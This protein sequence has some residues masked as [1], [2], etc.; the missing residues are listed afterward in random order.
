[1]PLIKNYCLLFC[2]AALLASLWPVVAQARPVAASLPGLHVVGSQIRDAQNHPIILKG[3]ARPGL[4]YLCHGEGPYDLAS[5]QAMQS[6]G[7]NAVNLPLS[8]SFWLNTDGACPD[9]RQTVAATIQHAETAGLYVVINLHSAQP[10]QSE[11]PAG[12]AVTFW[13][14]F[15]GAYGADHD[16]LIE[17]FNEPHNVSWQVWHDGGT[18]QNAN[19]SYQAV[20]MQQL[21]TLANTLAP[22][23]LVIVSGLNYGYDL[24]GLAQGYAIQS[25]NLIYSVHL[26]DYPEKQPADWPRAFGFLSG[27]APII[28]TE[29]GDTAHCDG[30]WLQRIMPLM[31]AQLNGYFAWAWIVTQDYCHY[32]GIISAWD[33]TPSPYGAPIRTFY[34]SHTPSAQASQSAP[35][36]SLTIAPAFFVFGIVALVMLLLTGAAQMRR[37]MAPTGTLPAGK[38]HS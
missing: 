12:D 22:K 11:M 7:V 1:M 34:L 31:H 3:V 35:A 14:Q 38:P 37:K 13:T 10:N 6:W 4:E 25:A 30:G 15:L 5:F 33:G 27:H 32:P 17:L 19:G 2:L 8:S 23:M 9:Y 28:A 29:F 26:Y 16:V 21:V 20:G 24:A 36:V 18:V